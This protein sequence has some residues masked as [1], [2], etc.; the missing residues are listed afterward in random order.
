MALASRA[1]LIAATLSL[2][3]QIH[4]QIKAMIVAGELQAGGLYSVAQLAEM[5]NVSRT[6]VRE[7]ILQLVREGLLRPE[8][9]RGFRVVQPSAEELDQIF[10]VRLMLEVPS[11]SKV[12]QIQPPPTAV[13]AKA[14]AIYQWLQRAADEG[15]LVEFLRLDREFHLGLVDL[16]GNRKLTRILADLRDHMYLPGL[17]ALARAGRL[18]DSGEEHLNL[19]AALERGDPAEAAE[20]TT[21]HISRTR[22]EWA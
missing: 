13:F 19:L 18:H 2:S 15:D 4:S 6:P 5:F 21:R 3:D 11:M 10:E 20:I 22:K 8:R 1:R 16:C 9:N 14:R 17:Q 12:A 7:A